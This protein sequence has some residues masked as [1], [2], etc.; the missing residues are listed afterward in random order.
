MSTYNCSFE[1]GWKFSKNLLEL[2]R[3]FNVT[4]YITEQFTASFLF[5]QSLFSQWTFVRKWFSQMFLNTLCRPIQIPPFTFPHFNNIITFFFD[6]LLSH[7]VHFSFLLPRSISSLAREVFLTWTIMIEAAHSFE[8]SITMCAKTSCL[9]TI[10]LLLSSRGV[11]TLNFTV[12]SLSS[13]I[14][15]ND[16]FKVSRFV[17]LRGYSIRFCVIFP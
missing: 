17:L 7:L 2:F 5:Q 14:W 3:H 10:N 12:R 4:L 6:V 15:H 9:E 13:K 1:N 8:H 16:V 11:E